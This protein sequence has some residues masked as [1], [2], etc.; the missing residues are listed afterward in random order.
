MDT[1]DRIFGVIDGAPRELDVIEDDPPLCGMPAK[2]E[3]EPEAVAD[4][5]GEF[6]ARFLPRRDE[7]H[8]GG[9]ASVGRLVP[10]RP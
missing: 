7:R 6:V 8:T 3:A 9:V 1:Y 4:S 2:P 10:K 5:L